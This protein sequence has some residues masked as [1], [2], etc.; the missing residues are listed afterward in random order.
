MTDHI[1]FET[2]CDFADGVLS[3]ALADAVREH[4]AGCDEC[5]ER[6]ASLSALIANAAALPRAIDPP[7][8]LWADIRREI[9][10]PAPSHIGKH[11]A[12][13]VGW[14]AAAA[15][16]IAVSSSALTILVMRGRAPVAVI[17]TQQTAP[18]LPARLASNEVRYTRDIDALQRMLDQRRDSLAPS[19]V[20]TIERSLRVADSAIAEAR[21]ALAHDP[22]NAALAQLFASNYER[23]IDLLKRATELTPRT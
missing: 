23:K 11:W 4:L 5:T 6:H 8:D 18:S 7:E 19:T 9:A 13:P 2:F 10:P 16:V 20:Q 21:A 22:S 14:L 3:V 17:A 12:I 1:S 15:V